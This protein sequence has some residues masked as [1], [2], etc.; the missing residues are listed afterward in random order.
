MHFYLWLA[1]AHSCLMT[2]NICCLVLLKKAMMLM[3][4]TLAQIKMRILLP[5]FISHWSQ[6]INWIYLKLHT[7][8]DDHILI[9]S[10]HPKFY[11]VVNVLSSITSSV[12]GY[13][14]DL[15]Q[16]VHEF[17]TCLSSLDLCAKNWCKIS[18]LVR[19]FLLHFCCCH[20]GGN[21]ALSLTEQSLALLQN[22][23]KI[24]ENIWLLLK[25]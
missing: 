4:Q 22:K 10:Y 24:W 6:H 21:A 16:V 20:T 5:I 1:F 3:L 8:F 9:V 14:S 12:A 15:Q 25:H 23:V 19:H 2:M 17:L 18:S 11:W 7:Y 13:L